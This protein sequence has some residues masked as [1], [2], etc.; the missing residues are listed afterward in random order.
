VAGSL[1]GIS[2]DIFTIESSKLTFRLK[3]LFVL[4]DF[5]NDYNPIIID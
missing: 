1:R 2:S 5:N 4:N 3:Y